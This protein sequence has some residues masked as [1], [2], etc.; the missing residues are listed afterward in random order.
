MHYLKSANT[1][2]AY[3]K[4]R[5]L[6]EVLNAWALKTTSLKLLAFLSLKYLLHLGLKRMELSVVIY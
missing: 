3:L 4:H 1:I 2:I 5:N 6:K